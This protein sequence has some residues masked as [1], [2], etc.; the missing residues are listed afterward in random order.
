MI[1]RAY[2]TAF[3]GGVPEI[4]E[5]EDTEFRKRLAQI[6]LTDR[7]PELIARPADRIS[8]RTAGT[9]KGHGHIRFRMA[10]EIK[11]MGQI[12][13]QDVV[14]P[15]VPPT[16]LEASEALLEALCQNQAL[17]KRYQ[18]LLAQLPNG[19]SD[20]LPPSIDP[21]SQEIQHRLWAMEMAKNES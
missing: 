21:R 8:L 14:F 15:G 17:Q 20:A 3:V 9:E 12:Q 4:A 18:D 6:G 11:T 19:S 13:V 16:I 1:S 7:V 5:K 2:Q 10:Q